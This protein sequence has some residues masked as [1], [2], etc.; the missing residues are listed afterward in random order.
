VTDVLGEDE[1]TG[2]RLKNTKTG[3]E[4]EM[5]VGALFV[6]I[7]HT[8]NTEFLGG[9]IELDPVGYVN[10]QP[11]TSRTSVEGIFA[12]GDAMDRVYRQAV[13]A[14]GTGCMAAIDA[15]RWLTEQESSS[16]PAQT[17]KTAK[18]ATVSGA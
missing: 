11:G 8:P 3:E 14:A 7:G 1:V 16:K 4:S 10:V 12:C 5:S 13:T 15:E 6:A 18:P 2:L 17:G 9:V